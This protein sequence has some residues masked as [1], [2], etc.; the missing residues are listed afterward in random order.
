MVY[1][2]MMTG[3]GFGH[4]ESKTHERMDTEIA[5]VVFIIMNDLNFYDSVNG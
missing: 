2:W 4:D 1:S 5:I 3:A